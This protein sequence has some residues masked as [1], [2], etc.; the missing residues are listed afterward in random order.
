[1]CIDD[2]AC[3]L[4]SL[5]LMKFRREDGEL[6]VEAFE[7]AV[8]TVFLAQEIL[9]GYSSYPTPEIE[10]NAKAYRQLG[11][12]YANLG[13][14]LM[15]RGPALRLGRGTR[16]R[17]GDHVADD[18]S[19]LPQVGRDRCADGPVRRLPQNAAAMIGVIAKHRAA[20]GNI[21]TAESVP[22]DL[23][24][25]L[26][27]G[28]GRRA[29]PRRGARL[30]QRAV[31]GARADGLPRRRQPRLDEPRPRAAAHA[32]RSRRLE[33]A[34]RSTIEVATDEGPRQATQF[35]VN[36]FERVV[37]IETGRGYRIQGTPTHR[38]KVVDAGRQT[39]SG[40]GSPRSAKATGFR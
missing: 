29:Q 24:S 39:G 17:G 23:L 12:G 1:M 25:R 31:D 33:V 27:Q 32:R 38:I 9:V 28:V 6:D 11:L 8:D 15:A 2:S 13:A 30:P 5:N 18:G 16:V 37:S 36:G 4:A 3:N 14:L 40:S 21:E 19:R 22:G 20:V 26:P 10:R 34:G 7:H 35:Y